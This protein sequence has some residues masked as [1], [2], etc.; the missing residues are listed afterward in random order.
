MRY[1]PAPI[2]PTPARRPS[3]A[4]GCGGRI[5]CLRRMLAEAAMR[6]ARGLLLELKRL[7]AQ[8]DGRRASRTFLGSPEFTSPC[9][10]PRA[11]SVTSMRPKLKTASGAGHRYAYKRLRGR[12]T[13][14]CDDSGAGALPGAVKPCKS[15]AR[16]RIASSS[17]GFCTF[18]LIMQMPTN[19]W[20]EGRIGA[21]VDPDSGQGR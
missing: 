21:C 8:S 16:L 17:D 11:G 6:C 1:H 7:I 12:S 18:K 5:A 13:T 20:V 15:L 2:E 3:S 14:G 10:I 19:L 4:A 9:C